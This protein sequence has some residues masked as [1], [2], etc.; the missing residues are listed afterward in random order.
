MATTILGV[1]NNI[2]II[3]W[4]VVLGSLLAAV[5][6]GVIFW[7]DMTRRSNLI[8]FMLGIA[9]LLW[10]L[11]YA[12]FEGSTGGPFALA[13]V[14]ALYGAAA[15]VPIFLFLFFYTFSVIRKELHFLT[16]AELFIPYFAIVGILIFFPSFIVERQEIYDGTFSSI[17][18]GKGFYSYALY[19]L[20]F[21]IAGIVLLIKK[22]R[23]SAGIFRV[24]IRRMLIT[25]SL[26]YFGAVVTSLFSPLFVGGS[27]LFWGGHIAA[28]IMIF[29]AALIVIKYNYWDIKVVATEFFIAIIVLIMILEIF[30]ANTTGDLLVK[31]AIT[32]LVVLSCAFL[33]G[34]VKREIESRDKILH[35]SQDIDMMTKRLKVLD[36]KKSEFLA[37]ASH[38]LRDPL[39]TVKGYSSM[40]IDGSFGELPERM[41][42]SLGKIFDSSERLLTMISDFMDISR[43]ESGNMSY[44]FSVVNL[45]NI[46]LEIAEEMRQVAMRSHLALEVIIDEGILSNVA[47]L[48]E[49]DEGKLRQ[50]IS[51]LIDN[52]IKY[53]PKGE[54]S[55][56]LSKSPDSKKI[57]FSI[58]DTGIGMNDATKEK[59]FKKFSRAEGVSKVYTEGSG[60]GLY[61]AS[62]VIKKHGGRIWVESKGEGHGSTFY[63]ELN[64]KV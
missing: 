13:G 44:V 27:D 34:S 46:I 16:F 21:L 54:V 38:H 47:F 5:L 19:V 11:C 4:V 7:Q 23:A 2:P 40:L 3:G 48:T 10:G 32:I 36:K 22:Y 17:V 28:I 14:I 1:I 43:I 56:L 29:V 49:G 63:V 45:K 26:G 20:I 58:S 9:V 57:L 39:T 37:I 41:K 55:I 59:I 35:L 25:V 64:A 31:T 15:I 12:F 53:T 52:A 51:N 50:V 62:E 42:E 33:G 8:F 61:V 18:V 6:S 24:A 60:L 30:Y